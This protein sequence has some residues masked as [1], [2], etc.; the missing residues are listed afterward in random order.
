M[1]VI[2]RYCV[3][4]LSLL[5]LACSTPAPEEYIETPHGTISVAHLKTLCREQSTIITDDIS[6]EAY[7]VANDLFG[8]YQKAVILCDESGGIEL[9]VDCSNTSV[10]FPISARVVVHCTGL[11]LGN[12]GGRIV[13]GAAPQGSYTVDRIAEKDFGRYLL[14]DR[15]RPREIEPRHIT[16]EEIDTDLIGNYVALDDVTFGD[17]ASLAWCD[18]DAESGEWLTTS[19]HIYDRQGNTLQ[20]RTIAD[21]KYRRES[22]PDGYGTVWG[23]VEYF[24]KEFSLRIVNHRIEFGE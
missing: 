5:L 24:N 2:V 1:R 3:S 19:R 6:I 7:V 16:M 23:I 22:I 15:T 18:R 11:A 13:L 10:R 9:A 12:Y 21:C 4:L 14:I 20:V 17:N 8:E